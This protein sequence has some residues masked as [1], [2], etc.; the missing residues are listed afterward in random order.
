VDESQKCVSNSSEIEV[1]D[2]A[3]NGSDQPVIT[4]CQ[5]PEE[6]CSS[7]MIVTS[8]EYRSLEEGEYVNDTIIDLSTQPG[9]ARPHVNSPYNLNKT[10]FSY[11][12]GNKI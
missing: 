9:I 4:L 11:Q 1:D 10:G 12:Y 7:K 5:F 2:N 8:E 3:D 6:R